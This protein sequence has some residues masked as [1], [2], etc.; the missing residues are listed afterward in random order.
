MV[1][2]ISSI[3]VHLSCFYDLTPQNHGDIQRRSHL[4]IAMAKLSL[5]KKFAHFLNRLTIQKMVHYPVFDQSQKLSGRRAMCNKPSLHFDGQRSY[6]FEILKAT[7]NDA[8]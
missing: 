3:P 1:G 5:A 8:Q 4:P 6:A 7:R 2:S